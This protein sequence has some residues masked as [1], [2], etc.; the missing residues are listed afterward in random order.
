MEKMGPDSLKLLMVVVHGFLN[1]HNE[2]I[3]RWLDVRLFLRLNH[4]QLLRRGGRRDKG[5]GEAV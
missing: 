3:R 5:R 4:T 1:Y 2:G